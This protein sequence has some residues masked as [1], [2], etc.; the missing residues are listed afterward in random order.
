MKFEREK[1]MT[2]LNN[3]ILKKYFSF[4]IAVVM[5]LGCFAVAPKLETKATDSVIEYVGASL[6]LSSPINLR[7]KFQINN[8]DIENAKE[9]GALITTSYILGDAALDVDN[10]TCTKAVAFST[11]SGVDASHEV[12]EAVQYAISLNGVPESDYDKLFVVRPYIIYSDDTVVYGDMVSQSVS[13][14]AEKAAIDANKNYPTEIR[15][16]FLKIAEDYAFD[17]NGAPVNL[18]AGNMKVTEIENLSND[19]IEEIRATESNYTITRNVYYVSA[20]GNDNNNGKTADTAWKT[21]DK[22]NKASLLSG[23]VVLFKRGDV[24]RGKL[25]L[26][27]GVT[28]S[29]YGSGAKPAINGSAANAADASKWTRYQ[30]TNIWV[31]NENVLDVGNI[32]F[33]NGESY[34]EKVAPFFVGGK[35]A[36]A[37][38]N[39]FDMVAALD[40]DYRFF[41]GCNSVV[42][43]GYPVS[44]SAKGKLYLHCAEGNPG[45]VFD[46]IEICQY[47]NIVSG[48]NTS[49]VTIDNLCVKYGGSHAIGTSNATNFTVRNCEIGWIGGSILRYNTESGRAARYGNGVQVYSAANGFNVYNN[50][51]YQIFDTGITHQQGNLPQTNCEFKNISYTDNVI[52]LCEWSVEYF[53]NT[54]NNG[55]TH[56]MSNIDISNNI[57]RL[58]GYGFGQYRD[59]PWHYASHIMSW[60]SVVN[61]N[62]ADGATVTIKDNILDRS[63][64]KMIE[65]H[66]EK[67]ASLPIL[68]GNTFIQNVNGTLGR[69]GSDDVNLNAT[70]IAFNNALYGMIKGIDAKDL[71]YFSDIVG[72]MDAKTLAQQTYF[73][74]NPVSEVYGFNVQLANRKAVRYLKVL[75]NGVRITETKIKSLKSTTSGSPVKIAFFSDPHF[76]GEL[77]END[78]TKQNLVDLYELRKNT[79]RNSTKVTPVSLDFGDLFDRTVIGGDLFDFYSEGNINLYKQT[80]ADKYSNVLTALGNHET[81]E[82]FSGITPVTPTPQ[83][84][85]Y[86]VL[87]SNVFGFESIKT[88]GTFTSLSE[89]EAYNDIYLSHNLVTDASGNEKALL[90]MM[91]N[92]AYTYQFSELHYNRLNFYINY[93]KSHKIPMLIFQHSPISTGRSSEVI[94]TY[95]IITNGNGK[96]ENW[97]T[98][99]SPA[100]PG[101]NYHD[102]HNPM[103]N[104]VYD[105]IVNNADVIK[106]IFCGHVH[107]NVYTEIVAKNSDGTSAII[108]Q[109]TIAG[110]YLYSNINLITV[111]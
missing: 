77:T 51:I 64:G 3:K 97:G 48:T 39:D 106:G 54:P 9:Y 47:G 69:Y 27:N 21:L 65:I 90:V 32:V 52:E 73:L 41:G 24:F 102:T 105:L 31:Y 19:R 38:G 83:S 71:L 17:A 6:S 2:F 42:E 57:M 56:K 78:K 30:N 82:G 20:S 92:Q 66:A 75:S 16:E 81:A 88:S 95:D 44:A 99:A 33:N 86:A 101:A 8:S 59:D 61:T 45:E 37:D 29:A 91:D 84:E 111:E 60:W 11:V 1:I 4:L 28:Y 104:R 50:Y 34:A 12:G 72:E 94:S 79:F 58:S 40:R 26:K 63:T 80:V 74:E 89:A 67:Q 70:D 93:A 35:F 49:N 103:T 22:V 36:D 23:D 109:Y 107:N 68:S 5:I 98:A 55:Y 7:F 25:T 15:G 14:V 10:D 53:M 108:P 46:S 43:N 96:G 110:N 100:L 76:V 85:I 87:N 13:M 18:G 62:N